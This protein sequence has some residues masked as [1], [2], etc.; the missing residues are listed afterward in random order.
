MQIQKPT[1]QQKFKVIKLISLCWRISHHFLIKILKFI[2][3]FIQF[4]GF[5]EENIHT[6]CLIVVLNIKY[7]SLYHH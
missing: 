5:C 7:K 6:F 4:E 3:L 2:K 1:I